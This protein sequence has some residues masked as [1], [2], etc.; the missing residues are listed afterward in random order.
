[1]VQG[2][3]TKVGLRTPS[4]LLRVTDRNADGLLVFDGYATQPSVKRETVAGIK[5]A[6]ILDLIHG[7]HNFVY[8]DADV[9]INPFA[10]PL[11]GMLP[12]NP[13]ATWDMQFQVDEII[14]DEPT[15]N[16][17]WMWIRPT[18]GSQKFWQK[19]Q[20]IWKATDAWDQGIVLDESAFCS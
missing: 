10:Q 4:A 2:R 17:G 16:I 14:N 19:C 8:L 18:A 12:I 9:Y 11:G 13:A 5:F 7:G 3:L 20:G 15:L 6:S 1:M